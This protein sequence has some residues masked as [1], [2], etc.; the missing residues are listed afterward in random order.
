[1]NW[2]SPYSLGFKAELVHF[3][4][5]LKS[6]FE[7]LRCNT[8][9]YQYCFYSLILVKWMFSFAHD[10]LFLFYSSN[11]LF[12]FTTSNHFLQDTFLITPSL[13]VICL[14]RWIRKWVS[15]V[16]RADDKVLPAFSI[17]M[18]NKK[19]KYLVER[20]ERERVFRAVFIL[21]CKNK[22]QHLTFSKTSVEF[23]SPNKTTI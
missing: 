12:L 14:Q 6:N 9:T 22:I 2:T 11:S 15:T 20:M 10:N 7:I 3:T 17:Y 16:V 23:L 4:S 8:M 13:G 19:C 21:L 5:C 1:M 18:G